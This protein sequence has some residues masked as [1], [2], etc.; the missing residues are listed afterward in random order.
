MQAQ[1]WIGHTKIGQG[2]AGECLVV[3]ASES[4]RCRVVDHPARYVFGQLNAALR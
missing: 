3:V 4:Q 1:I 2:V